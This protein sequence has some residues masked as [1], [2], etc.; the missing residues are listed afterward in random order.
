MDSPELVDLFRAIHER[1]V[2]EPNR[3]ITLQEFADMEKQTGGGRTI[4][5]PL[6]IAEAKFAMTAPGRGCVKTTKMTTSVK[7][8][9]GSK[10]VNMT[11]H[12]A[13]YSGAQVGMASLFLSSYHQHT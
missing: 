12:V 5:W 9:S 8:G 13:G 7:K 11:V 4:D 3:P 1:T 6:L 10:K 2:L